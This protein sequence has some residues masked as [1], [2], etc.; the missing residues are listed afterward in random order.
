MEKYELANSMRMDLFKI[1]IIQNIVKKNATRVERYELA[2]LFS[3]REKSCSNK[4]L[5]NKIKIIQNLSA[6][7]KE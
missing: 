2:N 1:K 7:Q 3:S 6:V 5:E 4:I